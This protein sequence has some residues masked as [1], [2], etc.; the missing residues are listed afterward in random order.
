MDC[1]LTFQSRVQCVADRYSTYCFDVGAEEDLCINGHLTLGENVADLGGTKHA[2]EAFQTW[3]ALNP[4]EADD[5]VDQQH[6][7]CQGT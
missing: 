4:V 6:N 7:L 2:Y 1:L 5:Q 3:K